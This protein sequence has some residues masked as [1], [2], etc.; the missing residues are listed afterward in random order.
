MSLRY[1]GIKDIFTK[2]GKEEFDIWFSGEEKEGEF[3]VWWSSGQIYK[4]SFW[5]NGELNGKH[6][7]WFENGKP[8]G[9]WF[10]KNGNIDGE[11]KAWRP[12]GQMSIHAFYK[13]NERHGEYKNWGKMYSQNS[14]K[15]HSEFG[16]PVL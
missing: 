5:K 7:K 10:Y 8:A 16:F 12:S 2:F 15:N 13:N 9:R 6:E 14:E 11:Y 4:H 3:K 1:K